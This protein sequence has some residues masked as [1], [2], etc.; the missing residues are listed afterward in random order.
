MSPRSKTAG[1]AVIEVLAARKGFDWWW[2]DIDEE[3]RQEILAEL[4]EVVQLREA[5][6]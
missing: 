5:P 2:E 3:N 4:N 6:Q 1:Q